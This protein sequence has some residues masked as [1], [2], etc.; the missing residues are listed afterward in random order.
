MDQNL[1]VSLESLAN[2][3]AKELFDIELTRV[4]ENILDRNTTEKTREITLKVKIKPNKE[5]DFCDVNVT[6]N[7]KLAAI[8]DVKTHLFI[9]RS[10]QGRELVAQE[11]NPQ[12]M[13]LEME[14]DK[15]QG[16]NIV[17]IRKGE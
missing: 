3:A 9:G 6:C 13:R 10:A 5:R 16:E 14:A 1:R 12:Q 8:D 7:A 4:L 11:H 2:G 15:P 17:S